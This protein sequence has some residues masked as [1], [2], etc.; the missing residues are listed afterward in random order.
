VGNGGALIGGL[1]GYNVRRGG[2]KKDKGLCKKRL[3]DAQGNSLRSEN[4]EGR[5]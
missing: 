5:N 2:E 4:K 1:R 3:T